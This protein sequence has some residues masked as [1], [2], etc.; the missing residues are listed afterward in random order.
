MP[1]HAIAAGAALALAAGPAAADLS[2]EQV[3][4]D[5]QEVYAAM[6]STLTAASETYADGRLT[7]TGLSTAASF[8]GIETST[9]YGDIALVE[10]EDGTLAIEIPA[11]LEIVTETTAA[12]EPLPQTQTIVMESEGL[13]VIAREEGAGRVYDFDAEEVVYSF[14]DDSEEV[15]VTGSATITGFDST[16]NSTGEGQTVQLDQDLSAAT[17]LLSIAGAGPDP[18]D[19]TYA[20]TDVQSESSGTVDLTAAPET[21]SLSQMGLMFDGSAT[22]GGSATTLTVSSSESGPFSLTGSSESGRIGFALGADSLT[23]DL[24]STAAK[25]AVQLAA[26]PVPIT[27]S[28]EE[29]GAGFRLPVGASEEPKPF[30]LTL[31]LRD[32]VLDDALWSLFDP[33][34]QLPRDP[35]TLLLD[36]SGTALMRADIFGDPEAMATLSGPPGELRSLDLTTLRVAL[37]GAE[38]T[39]EGA[40][41][42][43][44]PGVVP[45]PVGQV[46]LALSGGLALIDRLVALGFVPPQQAAMAKGM[47]GMVAETVGEDQLRSV[48]E[49]TEGG[50]ITANGVPLQ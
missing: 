8:G 2:A 19:M 50:G 18:F 26:F 15:P 44:N 4:A 6:G 29:F 10:R 16:L 30:G 22:H 20:L 36:L 12:G 35:A 48:I 23:Y 24:S 27:G 11:R 5:W 39:G 33:T 41:T 46:T 34:G 3:W 28:L 42:F 14:S 45:Q 47:V 1:K 31:S 17:V 25:M 49:F 37:A 13:E 40:V 32:L 7:L 43:P 38:L 21:A 9:R